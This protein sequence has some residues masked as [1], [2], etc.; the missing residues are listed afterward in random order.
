MKRICVFCGSSPGADP[1][2]MKAAEE[3]GTLLA[4][5][6]IGLVYGGS[7]FGLMGAISRAAIQAGG[8]VIGVI[9]RAMVE[10]GVESYRLTDVRIVSDMHERKSL[11]AS[12]ADGFI[13]LPGGYGTLEEIFEVITWAQ[14]GYHNKPCGLLNIAG[15][16]DH[17]FELLQHGSQQGF[18]DA[19][20]LEM[21]LW[22]ETPSLLLDRFLLYRPP[23][24]D[25]LASAAKKTAG[26]NRQNGIH[27]H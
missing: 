14:L 22:D 10:K 25:K 7:G 24:V 18:I 12:L 15:Y 21:V 9:P 1:A 5:R 17:L 19:A 4:V 13:A 20:H 26:Y 16:Y 27:S 23:E 3:L 2:F 11:M 6:K 8:E